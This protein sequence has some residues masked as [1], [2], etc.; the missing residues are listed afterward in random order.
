MPNI[1][2]EVVSQHAEEA[3]FLWLQRAHAV[4][5]PHYSPKQFADLDERLAAHVDG[6]RVAGVEGWRFVE[7]ALENGGPEEFFVAAVLALDAPDTRFEALVSRVQ[8]ARAALPGLVS[9]LGWA[10]PRLS[11]SRIAA[12]LGDPAPL[13]QYLGVAACAMH[14]HDPGAALR[15]WLA[16]P[17]RAVRERALRAAG[18]LGRRDLLPE[19]RAALAVPDARL[20]FWAAWS[21]VLLGDRAAALDALAGHAL[22]PGPNRTRALQVALQAMDPEAAHACLMRL[23][24]GPDGAARLRIIGAGFT[25]DVRYVRWLIE[26][27]S[28]PALARVAAEAFVAIT[29][30]DFNLD[31]LETLPPDGFEDGPTDDPDDESVELPEDVALPWP[32]VSRV[33]SWWNERAPRFH[34]GV[35]YFLGETVTREHCVDVLRTGLQRQRI[36]AALHRSLLAPGDVLFPTSAPAWRQCRWLERAA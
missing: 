15:G 26:Q 35:R 1:L 32:D 20:A 3:S 21:A 6:L 29:G 30:A 23:A 9:A 11:G 12:L 24:D 2:D 17:A 22:R 7:D 5:A 25:G 16:S 8:A 31:G 14:R 19:L 27:M 33:R 36:A 4:H 34:T 13:R 10:S 28:R 18:E